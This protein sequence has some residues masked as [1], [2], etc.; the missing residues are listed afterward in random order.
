MILCTPVGRLESM[1]E[2]GRHIGIDYSGAQTP[3]RK[4]E[5]PPRLFG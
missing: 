1:S 3:D 4:P 5:G 2:F